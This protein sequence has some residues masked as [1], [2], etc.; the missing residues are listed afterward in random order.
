MALEWL[1]NGF[2]MGSRRKIK[3]KE[4]PLIKN[5]PQRC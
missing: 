2:G 4:D 3:K 5:S 1:W